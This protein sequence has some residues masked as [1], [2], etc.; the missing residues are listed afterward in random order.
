MIPTMIAGRDRANS[1]RFHRSHRLLATAVVT[2]LLTTAVPAQ[3]VAAPNE[4]EIERLYVEGQE[5][6]EAQDYTGAAESWTRLM[7]LLPESGDNQ[8]VRESVII[9]VLDAHLKAYNQLVDARGNKDISHLRAGK[10]TLD[11]YYADFKQVHGDRKGVSAA[12]QDKAA[13]LERVLANAEATQGGTQTDTEADG[14]D[15]QTE[16]IVTPA[17]DTEPKKD[18][19]VIVLQAQNDGTGLI[20]GG[21][22]T[23]AL[24]L[25]ALA[26]IPIGAVRGDQAEED[27]DAATTPAEEDAAEADGRQANAVLIAGAVLTPLLLG[28]ATAMLVIGLRQRRKAKEEQMKVIRGAQVVP[29]FGRGF[30]GFTL[31]GRF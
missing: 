17:Q 30:A 11:Q 18:R 7:T 3:A 29:S 26:M 31:T 14:D 24:G 27:F 1:D 22:V 16:P 8:A 23:A 6:L 10:Q 21:A 19:E 20:V 28:G 2:A 15:G 25:G 12:V 4:A 5:R 9:N 13:E